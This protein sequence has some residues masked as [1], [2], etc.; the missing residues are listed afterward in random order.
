VKAE[1]IVKFIR[2][3]CVL[4]L[5]AAIVACSHGGMVSSSLPDSTSAS[6]RAAVHP[7]STSIPIQHIIFIVQENRTFDNIFGGPQP[8]PGSD[9]VSAGQASDG[10][11]IPL[12]QQSINGGD[13]PDNF[14]AP[15][16]N[17][18]NPTMPR[19]FPVGEPA[20]CQM[21]GFNI[22]ASPAP[23]YTPPASTQYIYSY[24]KYKQTVPYFEIAKTYAVSDRFF[25]GH[26]SESYTGHQYIFSGQSNN[27]ADP[28]QY[29]AKTKCGIYYEDCIFTPWGCD[30]P[31]GTTTFHIDPQTGLESP[32]AS[33]PAPCFGPGAPGQ[34]VKYSALANLV[35]NKGLSWR[36]YGYSLCQNINALDVNWSIR[37]TSVWPTKPVM[38]D[39]HDDEGIINH[40]KVDTPNFRMPE[41]TFLKDINDPTHPLAN[42]TWILPG[43][44]SSDHPGVPLGN[45]GPAWVASIINAVG[46]SQYWNSTVIVTLWD[47]WGGFYDHVPPYVVRDQEGPGFRVPLLVVSPYV[48]SGYVSHTN[49]EF[50]T[51]LK[52]AEKT[53]GLGS[54][55]ATDSTPYLNNLDDFFGNTYNAF[56]PIPLK[57]YLQQ[58]PLCKPGL[59]TNVRAPHSR[60]AKM[61][62][63]D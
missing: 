53:F 18:C 57:Q 11:T 7:K 10:S 21:N 41:S 61:I 44:L 31:A 29:P 13:D 34:N 24:A 25:M 32:T 37:N 5:F 38:A 59:L 4:V 9:T 48:K 42:V 15:W 22:N 45:C 62:D 33:G 12:T 50:A 17:A 27:V 3:G 36:L 40:T 23:G 2:I 60:W 8:L 19:P 16:Y 63:A 47:D 58:Y 30:A 26:N 55:G 35:Q 49:T 28:P 14:H 54:L 56:Q 6:G 46:T 51:L 43:L 20:P 52:F 39:C 1:R